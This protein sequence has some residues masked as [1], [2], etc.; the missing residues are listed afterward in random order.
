MLQ[1]RHET[2]EKLEVFD[3]RGRAVGSVTL[4]S[5]PRMFGAEKG[6]I[7]LARPLP[8]LPA[9]PRSAHAA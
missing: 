7:Y 3:E 1:A 5:D 2:I 9:A 6:T 4:P 8:S